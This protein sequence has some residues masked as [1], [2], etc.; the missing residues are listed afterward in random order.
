VHNRK[1]TKNK[2]ALSTKKPQTAPGFALH[3]TRATQPYGFRRRRLYFT[4]IF[5]CK[6]T[7]RSQ[8]TKAALSTKKLRSVPG[9]IAHVQHSRTAFD[10]GCF[11]SPLF[12]NTKQPG[13]HKNEAALSTKMPR[14][15]PG[16]IV[17]MQHSRTAFDKGGFISPLFFNTKQPRGHK[18]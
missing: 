13:G 18:K 7:E 12:F 3:C 5:Q 11:I 15:V 8:K 17:R 10:K 16:L 2:A 4:A 6:T 14:S 1:V 9:L